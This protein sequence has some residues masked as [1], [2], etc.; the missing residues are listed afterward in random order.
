MGLTVGFS[1]GGTV[2][3][4]VGETVGDGEGVGV[5]VGVVLEEN[6]P[7]YTR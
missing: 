3:V 4:G 1:V 2:D 7:L 5:G 6:V